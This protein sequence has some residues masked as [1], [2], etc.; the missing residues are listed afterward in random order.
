V[1][2]VTSGVSSARLKLPKAS[3]ANVLGR[4]IKARL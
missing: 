2:I 4:R 3:L 1:L